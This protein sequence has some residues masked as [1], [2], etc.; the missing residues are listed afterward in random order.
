MNPELIEKLI[1]IKSENHQLV[2]AIEEMSELQKELCK[3]LIG[4]KNKMSIIEE[5]A[6]VEIMLQQ[7]KHILMIE[8][9]I[10]D[11]HKKIK[12]YKLQEVLNIDN[13]RQVNEK[14]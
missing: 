1:E 3:N 8:E 13:E 9:P 11:I 14:P 2:K 10:I 4:H 6:D 7:V 12:I 5:I